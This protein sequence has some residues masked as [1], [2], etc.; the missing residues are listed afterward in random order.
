MSDKIFQKRKARKKAELKRKKASLAVKKRALIICEGEKTEPFYLNELVSHFGINTIDIKIIGKECGSDPVSIYEH[1]ERC[2]KDDPDFE[3]ALFVFDRD[4]HPN[5]S[6]A[7]DKIKGLQNRKSNKHKKI[8]PITSTP[9][10]ELWLMLHYRKSAKPYVVKGQNSPA[11]ALIKDLKKIKPF[12][13]YE[14]G[15]TNYFGE[16]IHYLDYAMKNSQQLLQDGKVSGGIKHHIN[17]STN[18]YELVKVLKE[19]AEHNSD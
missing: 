7:L 4:N 9:C 14:K 13:N 10:F 18:M 16:I 2:L 1:G 15:S 5:Y 3:Y 8:L 11:E 17:P 6:S 12:N 19:I